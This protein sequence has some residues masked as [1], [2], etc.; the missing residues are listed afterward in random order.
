MK[1]NTAIEVSVGFG[2]CTLG[3]RQQERT[4]ETKYPHISYIPCSVL[5]FADLCTSFVS[6][7]YLPGDIL[8]NYV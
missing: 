2:M 3:N 1:S 7:Y 5:S 8:R 4:F 6:V